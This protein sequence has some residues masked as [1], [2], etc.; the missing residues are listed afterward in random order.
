M[1]FTMKIVCEVIL[2]TKLFI[3]VGRKNDI[4][5][6]LPCIVR[7]K[8]HEMFKDYTMQNSLYNEKALLCI[9]EHYRSLI[10]TKIVGGNLLAILSI[11]LPLLLSFYGKNGFDFKSLATA[12]PYILSF[13]IIIVI[14]YFSYNQ[15]IEAKKLLKG[16][17][18]MNERLEEIFSE[19]YIEYVNELKG[20]KLEK[21]KN[22]KLVNKKTKS[23]KRN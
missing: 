8:E 10:K 6:T 22:K 12:L 15:F 16:E 17:D 4:G 14:L 9:I 1:I 11:A 19:L 20:K 13:T 18:G 3:N 23:T 21:T 7:D 2:K 5:D